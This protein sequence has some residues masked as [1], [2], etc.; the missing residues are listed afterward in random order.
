MSAAQQSSEAKKCILFVDDEPMLLEGLQR[1]LRSRRKD[2]DMLFA[3]GGEAAL[4][5]LKST[6][7]DVVVTDMRMPGMD[8]ATLLHEVRDKFPGA[9]RIVLSGHFE[10]EA[11]LRAIPVAH[12]F[13][14]KPCD[15][16][17]LQAA[18]TRASEMCGGVPGEA[19]RRIIRAV[20]TLPSPPKTCEQMAT[21][22]DDPQVST[23]RIGQ[24]ICQ[25]VAI[26]AKVLQL[27]NS[28][29]FSF[30]REVTDVRKAVTVLG[31][32]VL[33]QLVTSAEIL[34]AFHPLRKVRG[35]SLDEFG[36]HAQLSARIA[37]HLSDDL[38]LPGVGITAALLHDT[39]K[40]ILAT[41]LPNEFEKILGKAAHH[42][43]P[44]YQ[45]EEE[46]LGTSHAEIGAYLL[47]LWGLPGLTV[48]AVASHHYPARSGMSTGRMDLRTVVHLANALAHEQGVASSHLPAIPAGIDMEYLADAGVVD[49]LPG[50]RTQSRQISV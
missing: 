48:D 34:A 43:L 47:S 33:K 20:G 16:E 38:G 18:I 41:R 40:L 37:R 36:L 35:F 15:P 29:F 42:K 12:Q 32:E 7:V 13:L 44:C 10:V 3:A 2:W 26:A 49:L 9:M 22:M 31:L 19:T 21:A 25:D 1:S 45:V 39:G 11:G 24:I 46:I 30:S 50:W 28:A 8:G 5:I 23:E 17:R 4:A 27:A 6:R 14:A